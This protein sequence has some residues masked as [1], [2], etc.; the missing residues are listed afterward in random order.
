MKFYLDRH[1]V[2]FISAL[3]HFGW[4][5]ALTLNPG[6]VFS[7]SSHMAMEVVAPVWVWAL[8]SAVACGLQV[9]GLPNEMIPSYQR[10]WCEFLG[11]YGSAIW[12]LILVGLFFMS[13]NLTTG[14]TT[15]SAL[16]I[17]SVWAARYVPSPGG[18]AWKCSPK[19]K[20]QSSSR[21]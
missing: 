20:L 18:P 4:V 8:V 15:Y 14:D 2:H 13:G 17:S 16:A 5:V 19:S 10:Q 3:M 11:S 6:I 12:W 1:T 7:S 9:A 21:S